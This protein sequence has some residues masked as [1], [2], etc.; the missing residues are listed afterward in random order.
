MKRLLAVVLCLSILAPHQALGQAALSQSAAGPQ[1]VLTV[2]LGLAPSGGLGQAAVSLNAVAPSLVQGLPGLSSVKVETQSALALAPAAVALPKPQAVKPVE[3]PKGLLPETRAVQAQV[4]EA[5]GREETSNEG[6][7]DAS[8]KVF[9]GSRIERAAAAVEVPDSGLGSQG[10][11]L[12]PAPDLSRASPQGKLLSGKTLLYVVSMIGGRD[13]L[14]ER[15]AGLSEEFGFDVLVLGYPDQK[16]FAVSKGIKP[17][18]YIGADIGNHSRENIQAIRSQVSELAKTRRIDAVKTYLNAYAELEAE[19]ASGLGL[20]GHDPEAVRS[21]H[22]KSRARKLMNGYQDPSLHLPA[23]E[24]RSAEEARRAFERIKAAGF[25]RVVAKPDSGGGGWGVTLD[26]GSPEAAAA[27][28]EKIRGMIDK[29]VSEDPRKAR[30]KQ[31]DQKPLVLFEAQIPDGLMLDVELIVRDG[32][33]VFTFLSYNP[34]AFGNQERGTTYPAAS[35]TPEMAEL[36]RSQAIK[37]L[38]AV[39]LRDGNAHVEAIL[40]LVKGELAAPIV[41]INARMG[42]ADI[43]ASIR[44]SAGVDVMR[45]A[46]LAAFGVESVLK[47]KPVPSLLQHRFLIAKTEGRLLAVRGL[48]EARGDVFLSETFMR[49]GDEVK[50]ADLLGNITV[51]GTDEAESRDRLFEL[52]GRV[53][54]DIQTPDGRVVTQ[55]GLYSHDNAEGRTLAEDWVDRIEF[56]RAGPLA[57][58]L[59][60]PRS[61]L[62][63]FTP[64]W[65]V[66]AMAQELQAVALPLFSAAL[67]G[68]PAALIIGGIGY[69]LRIA[70][71]WMGSAFMRRFNPKWVNV[72]A[73]LTLALAGAVIPAAAALGA[74]SAVMFGIFLGNSVIG[75]LV[76][77]IN[78]GVAENLLPRLI[79]G[80]HNPAKLELGLNYAYQ[81]VEIACIAVAMFAAVP[82][83]NML[84]GNV[85]MAVSSAGIAVSSLWY[86]GLRFRE[87]YKPEAAKESGDAS[88]GSA[89]GL[90]D[91]L[92]YAFFRFM[93]FMVYG[94]LATALA[95]SVF[96]SPGAAG[97]MIGFY[98]GGSWLASLLA[99]LAF[100]PKGMGKRAWTLLGAAAAAAFV[101]SPCLGVPALTYALGGVL[102]GLI[103]INSNKWMAYYSEKLPQGKY[104]DLSKWM[105]TASIL[106]MLPIFAALSAAR[107]FPGVGALLAIPNILLGISVA[108]TLAAVLTALSAAA[109]PGTLPRAEGSAAD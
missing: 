104:R 31:I 40:T 46:L 12:A 83:L 51:R 99:T 100:L 75:G 72:W 67:F 16:D 101:W 93:H 108:V 18:N 26:I 27:A 53:R 45:E 56:G 74:S 87:P 96:A 77:G 58:I 50:A 65:T 5:L 4:N 66:N 10:R 59:S 13:Y 6:A 98:D 8:A 71:A 9:E 33:P 103:T 95:L 2:P 21:A 92:P 32:K 20:R 106:A 76:Y 57:R 60:L 1:P 68:L 85:M 35:L 30:S 54:I 39:G 17:E 42:G 73:L 102:G 62:L 11:A 38:D 84:G 24:A 80:N 36:A 37:A 69:I 79:I 28:Y 78:R 97:H 7:A 14:Y 82:L 44:E 49:P 63:G 55:D 94:V 81:W 89:L 64:A 61:F 86:A 91:Y 52:L 107:I 70:G 19:L 29:V 48:P 88:G 47:P 41:E 43:W 15:I 34:P 109:R 90:R 25:D 105:M 22:T 3:E 23:A